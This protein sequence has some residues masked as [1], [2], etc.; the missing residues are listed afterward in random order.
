MIAGEIGIM[1]FKKFTPLFV[2]LLTTIPI[3]AQ[4]NGFGL[5][6]GFVG[7]PM[8]S[9][10]LDAQIKDKM[11]M[12][13]SVGGFP[14]IIMRAESNF[15]YTTKK[16]WSPYF[17]A[18]FGYTMIFRGKG[19]GKD[20]KDIHINFGLS[21]KL[22]PAFHLNADIGLLYAPAFI[23]PFVKENL[24]GVLP[25]VPTIELEGIYKFR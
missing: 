6:L 24:K 11:S 3:K 19:E 5:K 12:N 23:N 15:R 22:W 9:L 13:F 16:N 8:I 1:C 18:G 25:V 21:R 4:I 20:L 10:L 17:Q 14:G 7:G 2:L